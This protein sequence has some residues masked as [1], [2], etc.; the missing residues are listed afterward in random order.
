MATLKPAKTQTAS[1]TKC[2]EFLW[3]L[4]GQKCKLKIIDVLEKVTQISELTDLGIDLNRIS[5]TQRV[6]GTGGNIT[7][8]LNVGQ[9]LS[10]LML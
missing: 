5:I 2:W 4:G 7:I 9:T 6:G 8:P 3:K 10:Y 1:T